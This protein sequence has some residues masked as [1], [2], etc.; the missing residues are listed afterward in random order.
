[1]NRSKLANKVAKLK[2]NSQSLVM[3]FP[4]FFLSISYHHQSCSP[5]I[6]SYDLV[7]HETGIV[8]P[9]LRRFLYTTEPEETIN[10]GNIFH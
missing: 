1:M 5:L 4:A 6:R 8:P 7:S 9:D 3:E 10:V 2:F